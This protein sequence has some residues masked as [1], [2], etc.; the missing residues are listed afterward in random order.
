MNE[1]DRKEQ[2]EQHSAEAR[3][4]QEELERQIRQFGGAVTDALQHGFEGRGQ[5]IGDRA[6]DVGRAVI[7]AANFGISEAGRTIREEQEKQRQNAEYAARTAANIENAAAGMASAFQSGAAK[8]GE[9]AASFARQVFAAQEPSPAEKI[10]SSA[11]K[12]FGAGLALVIVGGI[13]AFGLGVGGISC[14]VAA[15]AF[16]PGAAFAEMLVGDA[17]VQAGLEAAAVIGGAALSALEITGWALSAS[18]LPFLWMI[19]TGAKRIKAS[20]RLKLF[21]EAAESMETEQGIPLKM[22]ADL[23]HSRPK[24]LRRELRRYMH[25]G[26]LTAWLDDEADCLFLTAEDYRAAQQ[27]RAAAARAEQDEKEAAARQKADASQQAQD[28]VPANLEAARRF[29][30]VLEQEKRLMQD[31]LAVEELEKMQKTTRAICAWLEAHPESL[32]KARRFA[33]YYIPTT[34]KLLHTYNDVQGQQGENAAAIRQDIAGILHTLNLGYENL[35]NNL[36]S[37]VAMDISGEI[38]ALQGMLANDGLA[39]EGFL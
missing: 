5:E 22:L 34:L 24:K 1:Q 33:E 15:G 19:L 32:P 36:L 18:A 21:A 20:R 12:R 6:W 37:D 13:F 30:A 39:G 9:G 27:A 10:R 25:K 7:H 28:D 11:G 8:M 31:D 3:Q 17:M 4:V 23:T 26:W 35:Y 38:A 14:L 16:A 2:Q 29:A